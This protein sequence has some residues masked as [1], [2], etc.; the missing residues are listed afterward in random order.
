M[1]S[2]T[3]GEGCTRQG[4]RQGR[5]RGLPTV[6]SLVKELKTHP[7]AILSRHKVNLEQANLSLPVLSC[8]REETAVP[9][10]TSSAFKMLCVGKNSLSSLESKSSTY[11]K[12]H[13]DKPQTAGGGFAPEKQEQVSAKRGSKKMGKGYG[14]GRRT[15]G[16]G[17]K[18]SFPCRA[19]EQDGKLIIK[20]KRI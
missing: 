16:A 12:R 9:V 3:A 15:T 13:P 2:Q 8:A 4:R 18:G 14:V 5:Y 10:L 6:F 20:K 11:S 17:E 19:R 1:S 7:C